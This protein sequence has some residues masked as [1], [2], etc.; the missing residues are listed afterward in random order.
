M[1]GAPLN[2]IIGSVTM[3]ARC[4][5]TS[6]IRRK[7]TLLLPLLLIGGIFPVP[8]TVDEMTLTVEGM[9]CPL[10]VR[11]VQESLRRLP[12]VASVEAEL[13]TGRVRTSAQPGRSLD[14]QRIRGQV[15]R[16]GFHP[17]REMVI[18]ATGTI[19]QSPRGRLTFRITG[20]AENYVLLEGS[21]LRRLLASLSAARGSRVTLLGR[22]HRHPERLP[23]S[24]TV[25]SY[26]LGNP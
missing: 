10:C 24:L 23:P 21:E 6:A 11:G 18:R 3:V 22:I 9:S 19:E 25:L 5:E 7:A 15:L 20:A 12:G 14:L 26:E 4:G 1:S 2:R 8:A 13:S 17:V 16:A